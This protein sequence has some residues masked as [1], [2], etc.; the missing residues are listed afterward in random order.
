M[1]RLFR[2]GVPCDA[3][4]VTHEKRFGV[5]GMAAHHLNLTALRDV[6]IIEEGVAWRALRKT[7]HSQGRNIL[8]SC[9]KVCETPEIQ[10]MLLADMILN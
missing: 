9:T 6:T 8:V 4:I 3:D 10:Q 7:F 1:A 2:N 5:F